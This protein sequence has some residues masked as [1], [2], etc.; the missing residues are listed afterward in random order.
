M[1]LGSAV[2]AYVISSACGILATLNPGQVRY[3]HNM[4]ELNYFAR[5]R[6]LLDPSMT[7][8]TPS[9]L[10]EPPPTSPPS[11]P[12]SAGDKKL[13]RAMT[14]KLREFFSQTQHVHRQ[15]RYDQ[16]LD[17]MS[18]RLKADAALCWARSTLMRVRFFTSPEVEAEFLASAALTLET[19]IFCRSEYV[20]VERLQVVE[21]GIAAKRGRIYAK[22]ACLGEDMVLTE[23]LL[24]DLDPA[25]A[26]TFV[27][28]VS[29][30]NLDR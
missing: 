4:D 15:A 28:Q 9:C 18:A 19:R 23:A 25:I 22:G 27:V 6:P 17:S 8:P 24:R 20:T 30:A 2:W 16:L 21:R 10:S 7:P 13:P 14:V 29:V 5:T 1:M 11:A 12:L 26:L 3:R